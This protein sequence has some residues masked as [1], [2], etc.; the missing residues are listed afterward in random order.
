MKA[1]ILMICSEAQIIDLAHDI[2]GFGI[3][4]GAKILE[5][6]FYLPVGFH[7]CVVDPGVGTKRRALAIS[8]GR[9]DVLIGPDNGV[10]LPATRFL[11]GIKTV[12]VIENDKYMRKPVSA[13][14]HGRDVFAPAAA[15]LGEGVNIE[16]LGPLVDQRDLASAAY[17]EAVFDIDHIDATA[18]LINKFGSVFL[19]VMQKEMHTLAKQNDMITLKFGGKSVMLPYKRTFGDVRVNEEVI[20]DDDFGRVEIAINQGSFA[21]RHGLRPG[22][23]IRLH[24]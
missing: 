6:V 10:L 12:H 24:L 19:N 4:E 14:F 1:T 9:G 2:T 16:Q 7:I 20:L 17:E 15:H 21:E 23:S 5:S 3:T 22:D 13:I 18:V 8:T 11:G